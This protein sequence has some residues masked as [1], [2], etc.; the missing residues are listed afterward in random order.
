MVFLV[1][2]KKIAIKVA[3]VV[4]LV[5]G[6]ILS[7]F[8]VDCKYI[9]VPWNL[10]L[11]PISILLFIVN[12][13]VAL[14]Y[15]LWYRPQKY[16]TIVEKINVKEVILRKKIHFTTLC[17]TLL[18]LISQ[19]YCPHFFY[20]FLLVLCIS[21]DGIILYCCYKYPEELYLFLNHCHFDTI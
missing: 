18:I 5:C 2:K 9:N 16:E 17:P 12:G 11:L 13:I 6:Y 14:T 4:A 7:I 15:L 19:L 8:L 21:F 3:L 20:L 10:V 1:C